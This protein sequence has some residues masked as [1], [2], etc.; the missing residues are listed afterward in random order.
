MVSAVQL[1]GDLIA[2]HR[3]YLSADG[4]KADVASPKSTLGPI[5]GGAVRLSGRAPTLVVAEGIE[6]AL[7]VRDALADRGVAVWAALN[8][9]NLSRIELPEW[10]KE[11]V[12]AADNDPVGRNAADHLARRCGDRGL[13]CRAMLP[14]APFKD[15]NDVAQAEVAA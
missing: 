14:P 11:I 3:T 4:R 1:G 9:G 13:P 6:T 10:V 5:R 15:W 7:S 8:A 12:V 2:E